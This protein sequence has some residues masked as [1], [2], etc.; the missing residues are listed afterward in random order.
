[1]VSGLFLA[2]ACLDGQALN[3]LLLPQSRHIVGAV[4]DTEGKPVAG[5]RI[6]HSNDRFQIH[7]TDANG[8]F[9]L[10]T[11]APSIVIRKAGFRSE[12]VRTQDATELRVT[13]RKLTGN[14]AFPACAK[15]GRY[16][17]IEGW[18]TS[19]RFPMVPSVQGEQ[20][21]PGCRLRRPKLLHRH[22]F[23]PERDQAWQRADV[24]LRN[25]NRSGRVA[26]CHI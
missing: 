14:Q 6:D 3:E 19:F 1:M 7:Q 21:R 10:D 23:G 9:V 22:G 13:L 12:L 2:V 26:I 15:T 8:G 17:G 18:G 24:E 5:A 16:V 20:A 4:V 11:Q 25:A